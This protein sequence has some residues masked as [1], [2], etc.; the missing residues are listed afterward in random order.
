MNGELKCQIRT[1]QFDRSVWF[2]NSGL[3]GTVGSCLILGLLGSAS[4]VL[5]KAHGPRSIEPQQA[6]SGTILLYAPSD[7]MILV[8]LTSIWHFQP[9]YVPTIFVLHSV[10]A[11]CFARIGCC[12]LVGC[13]VLKTGCC[14]KAGC[15]ILACC[16]SLLLYFFLMLLVLFFPACR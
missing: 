3:F 7:L 15:C 10:S 13:C 9:A 12:A 2:L 16:P 6:S 8:P 1:D 11:P 14:T 5:G 4:Q